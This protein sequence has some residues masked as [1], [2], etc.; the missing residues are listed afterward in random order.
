MTKINFAGT[1]TPTSSSEQLNEKHVKDNW[2]TSLSARCCHLFYSVDHP[3]RIVDTSP[4]CRGSQPS[5]Q[6]AVKCPLFTLQQ[7]PKALRL[8]PVIPHSGRCGVAGPDRV[9]GLSWCP[10]FDKFQGRVGQFGRTPDALSL[11]YS[12]L[13]TFALTISALL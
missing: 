6:T 8:I 7:V 10:V 3:P 11:C 13:R 4:W 1:M 9:F 12:L 5:P 2:W